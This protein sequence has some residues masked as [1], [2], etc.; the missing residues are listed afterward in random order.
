MLQVKNYAY[1]FLGSNCLLTF[2]ILTVS[3]IYA[4]DAGLPLWEICVLVLTACLN[5]YFGVMSFLI[6]QTLTEDSK[7][8]AM[9]QKKAQEAMKERFKIHNTIKSIIVLFFVSLLMASCAS[10][11]KSYCKSWNSPQAKTQKH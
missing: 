1:L 3:T 8:A 10:T 2:L 9:Y 11:K 7:K 4:Y 6:Y 5:A